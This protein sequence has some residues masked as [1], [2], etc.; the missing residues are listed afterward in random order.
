MGAES[1]S[2]GEWKS[3]GIDSL[4]SEVS[5]LMF[6][7]RVLLMLVLIACVAQHVHAQAYCALRDP[8]TAIYD[9][10][11]EG[12]H[13]RSIIRTVDVNHRAE[14]SDQLPFTIHFD[15]L[16]RHTLYVVADDRGPLGLV[17]V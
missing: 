15:E 10:Y 7:S 12:T 13:H 9:L 16:G 4:S 8:V 17:H 5:L 3:R 6:Y 14:V 11:P 1:Q 2:V